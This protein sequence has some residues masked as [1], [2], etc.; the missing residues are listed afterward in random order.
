MINMRV[1]VACTDAKNERTR[2]KTVDELTIS[3]TG[4]TAL[5]TYPCASLYYYSERSLATTQRILGLT[6]GGIV[7]RNQLPESL[8][9]TR[10][11]SLA[12]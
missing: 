7:R 11:T 8:E 6:H 3:R 5:G 1:E 12:T 9:N 2:N 10:G 4:L